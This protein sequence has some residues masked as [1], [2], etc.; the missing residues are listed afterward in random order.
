MTEAIGE[1]DGNA[2]GAS[3]ASPAR[4]GGSNGPAS[5]RQG[6]LDRR[7]RR[8]SAP[9]P[10]PPR[11]S[12]RS[13]PRRARSK[14]DPRE[15]EKVEER[16]FALRAL[17]RKHRLTVADLPALREQMTA[18]L[19]ALEDGAE[20]VEQLGAARPPRRAP[21]YVAAPKRCRG[22][23]RRRRAA[24]C[25]GV[26]AELKPL[27]LDKAR[28]RTVLTPLAEADWGEHGC[29]R[30]H[31]EVATNPGAPVRAARHA[32]PRAASCRASCWR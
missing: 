21:V 30:V 29:E 25:G 31:F 16:L 9:P 18:R 7:S 15:L 11:R 32:S 6:L 28:F 22:R 26:A 13:R 23:G 17:A 5:A 8:P 12:P 19:A 10:K 24:R 27:R 2:G 3:R 1:L 20:N 14:L 4:R